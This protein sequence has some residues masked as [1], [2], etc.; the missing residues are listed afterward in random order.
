MC[1]NRE[2]PIGYKVSLVQF[3]SNGSPIAP[4]NSTTAA[5]DIVAN[6]DLSACP[7]SCFRPVGLAWDSQGRLFMSSDSTGE[8]YVITKDDGSGVADVSVPATSGTLPNPEGYPTGSGTSPSPSYTAGAGS[9]WSV[10]SGSYWAAGAAV[11]GAM[12]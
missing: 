3:D 9:A 7:G 4:S 12:I 6:Q 11:V 10:G 5:V 1:R 8:I 2:N